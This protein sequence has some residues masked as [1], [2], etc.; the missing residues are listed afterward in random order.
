MIRIITD[1]AADFTK[2]EIEELGIE[3][4]NMSVTMGEETFVDGVTLSPRDFYE[5]L[6]ET[7]VL[8]KTSQIAPYVF[9]NKYKEV[10]E[11]GDSAVVITLSSELSGTYQN[12]YLTADD[13][14]EIYPVDS[15]N[16]TVGEQ[17][18]VRQAVALRD[19]GLTAKEIAMS[20]TELRK[21]IRVLALLDTLEYL[22][23]GGRISSATAIVGGVL[24]IKP[25]IE[26]VEGKVVMAGK[27]RGSK[28]GNN[29]LMQMV[30]KNGGIDFNMPLTLGYS[31][32][33][34][35]LLD[36]YIE[37]SKSI[38]EGKTESLQT[39][40]IG[41]TIGTHAGPG[42]IAIGFFSNTSCHKT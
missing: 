23:K 5:K 16:V 17:C 19:K 1:S 12:A 41:P 21:N 20:L 26:I 27:A 8:P 29:L 38:W 34:K 32:T 2:E 30:E 15:L 36:K 11:A 4:I 35:D 39:L 22:K 3:V 31:G 25:V 42:A 6:I 24:S 37:D 18:L 13:F 28:N 10:D 7:D 33:S 40:I 14:D 9:E